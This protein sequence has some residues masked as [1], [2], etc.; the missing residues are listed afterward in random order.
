MNNTLNQTEIERETVLFIGD[1]GT[2]VLDLARMGARCRQTTYYSSSMSSES[3]SY[4]AE[5]SYASSE[6]E[7][8]SGSVSGGGF[9]FSASAS[10]AYAASSTHGESS[11]T[12]G[13]F[14][15]QSTVE[16]S[17]ETI[18][19]IGEVDITN[20]CGDMLGSQNQPSLVG[21]RLK[22]IWDL[23]IFEEVNYTLA[24]VNLLHG[25][26][27]INEAAEKCGR[28]KCGGLGICAIDRTFWTLLKYKKWNENSTFDEF[29]DSDVC[30]NQYEIGQSMMKSGFNIRTQMSQCNSSKQV[31]WG[32]R[33]ESTQIRYEPF[34][35][36]S[37]QIA[38][39]LNLFN[40]S[41]DFSARI[42]DEK[43]DSF[44]INYGLLSVFNEY[45]CT[46][47]GGVSYAMFCENT[48]VR[49]HRFNNIGKTGR[50]GS[51][52]HAEV[53]TPRDT[54]NCSYTGTNEIAAIM[55]IAGY[56]YTFRGAM[57]VVDWTF[58]TDETLGFNYVVP[59]SDSN[60]WVDFSMIYFC[61]DLSPLR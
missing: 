36:E 57:G 1:Y 33:Y 5:S 4:S 13:S 43:T 30:L 45:E 50:D 15:S 12:S 32:E 21:Y 24:K 11:S 34:C 44:K 8:Y 60:A 22:A 27:R 58:S 37:M 14:E 10:A 6:E 42:S 26:E 20:A 48:I 53:I 59:N 31:K 40:R 2:H 16:Y 3:Y 52:F 35:D 54:L 47:I 23:P 49:V 39:G 61:N 7:S 56:N 28:D 46:S 29:W 55:V 41:I 18:D 19:C 51:N 38:I 17:S 9:G 25:L